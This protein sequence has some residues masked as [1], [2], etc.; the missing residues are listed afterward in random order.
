MRAGDLPTCGGG[1]S[2]ALFFDDGR[3]TSGPTGWRMRKDGLIDVPVN[4]SVYARY[5]LN[6]K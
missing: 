4:S 2:S 6:K 5:T 3:R 1:Y